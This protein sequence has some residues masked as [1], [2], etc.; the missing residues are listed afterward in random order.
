M[1][2]RELEMSDKGFL[3]VTMQ[4]APAF[5]EEFNA[6]YDTEHLPERLAVPGFETAL[7]FVCI[8]GHPRYLAMYDLAGPQVLDSPE[9][10]KI[11]FAN[12]SP[13]TLRVLRRVRVYRSFGRQI[14][15]DNALTGTCAR[16]ELLRFR[17]RP[18][19]ASEE[20]VNGMR[21]NFERRPETAQVRVFA[22]EDRASIDFIGFVEQHAPGPAALDLKL[23]GSHAAAID[24]ANT[25]APY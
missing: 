14:Y 16:V 2:V 13:W 19:G 15:P 10:L 12:S 6:W 25:Y 4:P 8:S 3:L 11:A 21:A 23:F 22:Y 17:N 7:R 18:S 24:L 1:T 20:I 5:E 9:Y